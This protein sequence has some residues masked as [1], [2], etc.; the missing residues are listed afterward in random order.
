VTVYIAIQDVKY[1]STRVST[2]A[3]HNNSNYS[4]LYPKDYYTI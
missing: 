1:I 2:S 4:L 3:A